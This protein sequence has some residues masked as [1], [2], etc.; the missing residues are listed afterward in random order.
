MSKKLFLLAAPTLVSVLLLQSYL[1]VPTFDDQARGDP[2]RLTRYISGSLADAAIL[3]PTL[4]ADSASSEINGLVFEGLIDRDEN[5]NFRPR[6]AE[7]WRIF[8][9]AYLVADPGV[10]LGDGT[11]ASAETLRARIQ[12]AA[13]QGALGPVD[14]VEVVPGATATTSVPD[15]TA[16]PPAKGARPPTVTLT[17]RRP[18]RIKLT[19]GA[20][21]QDLFAKLDRVLAGYVKR[22]A[23]ARYVDG[24]PA[25]VKALAEELAPVTEH[26]PVIVFALRRGV[27]FHDG[28]EFD[29]GDVR[30]TYETIMDPRNLSPRVSDFEPIKAVEPTGKY[31]VRVVYKR[32]FQPGFESWG[33]GIL[34]AHLLNREALRQE[35]GSLGRD[36]D[37]YSVRDARFNRAPVGAG[38]F[39]FV[40]WRTDEYVKLARFDRYWEGPARF[41]DYY[42]RVLPDLVTE[43]L[44]FYAGTTDAYGVQP[45]Q[46]ARLRNDPRFHT[47]SGLALGYTYIGYNMRR[48]PFQDA[49][50]RRALGMA[51][52]VQ[53]IIDYVLYGQA[54]RTTGP[55]PKQT[56]FYDPGVQPIPYDPAGALRLLEEAGYRRNSATGW[57]E[58]EGRPL[59]FTFITNHGNE[60]RKAIMT[61]AQNAWRRLGI[62]VESLTLEW[63]VFIKERVN[64]LDFDAVVL[65]WSMGLDADLYQLFHASQ[66]GE[67]QL[68]FVGYENPRADELIVRIRQEYDQPRQV[69]MA[70]E[71]HRLIAADQPYTF[72]YVGKWTALLDRKIVRL[73]RTEDGQPVYAPIVP[74]KLGGYTFHFNE[75][76]KTPRPVELSPR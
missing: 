40:E 16:P 71:L 47:F 19:L 26:N 64:K 63:A 21:D 45:H 65:G 69:A 13:R 1:W 35:A 43:E 61:I 27:L 15:P 73:V 25:A 3:N 52:N 58:K 74:T 67:F 2:R 48:P 12:A 31:E 28:H 32:L 50:V 56:D 54:E 72:L 46:V 34:P 23:P 70:R 22:L 37:K 18:D 41:Q 29:S 33:M 11:P 30:F 6:L 36:P 57:L 4:S 9:E 24:P 68:N 76:I 66:T 53:E 5:L 17:V 39:R 20:V 7:S 8:E 10:R 51:I 62:Q 60:T 59:A 14:G 38:P 55:Y 75:W 44:T 49:R 42:M